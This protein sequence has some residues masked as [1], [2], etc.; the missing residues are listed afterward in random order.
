MKAC[1]VTFQS[2][3]NYGAVLQAYALQG[4]LN[5]NFA[6]A[7]ILDYH[8]SAIDDSYKAPCLADYFRRPKNAI[9]KGFQTIVYCGKRKK[10]DEFRNSRLSMTKYYDSHSISDAYDEAD[11]FIVGSDQVWNY[12]I[13]GR[14]STFYLDFAKDKPKCSYAASFG[15]S[16]IPE[17]FNLFYQ[18]NLKRIDYVSVREEAGAQIVEEFAGKPV[19]VMPDPTLLLAREEWEKLTIS[20]K[21]KGKYILVYKITKA[22]QLLLFAK[23]ISR[24]TGLPIVFIPNDLKDGMVGQLKT[25]VG[26]CEWLGY[27]HDAEY[28]ITNSFHGTVFSI[29]FSKKFFAEVSDR[30][31]PSTSRLNSLLKMFGFENRTIASF[32]Q[33][34]LEI[35][36]DMESV[37]AVLRVQS[38]KTCAFFKSFFRKN[39]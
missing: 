4:Y 25:N 17:E 23:K 26:P 37:D 1:I 35:E 32:T 8:N 9:F 11:V 38:G 34:M 29:L 3:Y 14:D 33:S 30:V 31:N 39:N 6:S 20:P 10:I 13:V 28:V 18:D 27:I 24:I 22:D 12:L 21:T 5:A 36:I 7:V 16:K 2:A 15:V 19:C